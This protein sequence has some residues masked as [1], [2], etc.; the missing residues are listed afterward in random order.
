M[1][2]DATQA[3]RTVYDREPTSIVAFFLSTSQYGKYVVDARE[4][5]LNAAEDDVPPPLST[6]EAGEDNPE[7]SINERVLRASLQLDCQMIAEDDSTVASHRAK[8]QMTAYYAPHFA[9]LRELCVE[10]GEER[11]LSSL[12]RCVPWTAQGGKSNVFFAKTSDDRYIIKQLKKAEKQS[13]LEYAPDYFK[14][15]QSSLAGGGKSCLAKIFGIYQ[16]QIEYASGRLPIT[17]KDGVLDFIVM[18]NLF[19]DTDIQAIYDLKGSE[20]DRY[21]ADAVKQPTPAVLL[22][23]NLRE[24][25]RS[26][27]TLTTPSAYKR[28]QQS[29][30]DDTSELVNLTNACV[31][32]SK[33]LPPPLTVKLSNKILCRFLSFSGR[34]GL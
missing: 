10:G 14:Y 11:Y 29:L 13:V 26:T 8:F 15:L 9:A 2:L 31:P 24:L 21:V 16:V 12:G 3:P 27:P 18:E 34:H 5:C 33:D 23:D 32:L 4:K 25:N 19:H 20:R 6:A 17:G 22:D 28:I 1:L 30:F 7:Y